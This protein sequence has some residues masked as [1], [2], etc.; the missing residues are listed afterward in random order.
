MFDFVRAEYQKHPDDWEMTRDAFYQAFQIEGLAGYQYKQLF[1]AG[2]NFGASLISLFHGEGDLKKTI[3][4]GSL[5]GW[6]SDNPTATWGGLIGFM[7][8]RDGVQAVFPEK[9]LSDL[10]W[11]SRTRKG[12]PDRTPNRI[13]ED[14]F[15]LMAE[16]ALGII[17]RMLAET[18]AGKADKNEWTIHRTK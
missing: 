2:I 7:L 4:I 18:G 6:D 8:G 1:D 11:I 3:R 12:F 14:S 17:E 10:Y 16:R 5:A 13:G 15:P 9:Q